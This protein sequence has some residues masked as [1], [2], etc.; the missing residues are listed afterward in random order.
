MGEDGKDAKRLLGVFSVPS[1]V[2][3]GLKYELDPEE[4]KKRIPSQIQGPQFKQAN[5]K[6]GKTLDVYFDYSLDP[7]HKHKWL[8]QVLGFFCDGHQR[9]GLPMLSFRS[10]EDV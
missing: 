1:Y 6:H 3:L 4:R 7:N 5:L 10:G 9:I 2:S 8:F